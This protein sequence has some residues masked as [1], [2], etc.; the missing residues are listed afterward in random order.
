MID[1]KKRP[2]MSSW[3]DLGKELRRRTLDPLYHPSYVIYFFVA[4]VIAGAA[5]I[6]LELAT[7]FVLASNAVSNA[8]PA[9]SLAAVRTAFISFFPALAGSACLQLIWAEGHQ[10]SLRAFAALILI[11]L[12]ILALIIGLVPAIPHDGALWLG[13]FASL[14]ALWMWWV[15]NAKQK[16]LMDL[17]VATGGDP[18]APLAGDLQDFQT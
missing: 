3:I 1:Q 9:P 18:S 15:A 16:D 14:V 6:W 2:S 8:A 11:V 12:L 5:G 10:R 4:V 7:Y 17:D 13:S